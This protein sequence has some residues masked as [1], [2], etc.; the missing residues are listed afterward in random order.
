MLWDYSEHGCAKPQRSRSAALP[1]P[2]HKLPQRQCGSCCDSHCLQHREDD[3]CRASRLP[4]HTDT[5]LRLESRPWH[6]HALHEVS[7]G[8]KCIFQ[9]M[10]TFHLWTQK[11]MYYTLANTWNL[12]SFFSFFSGLGRMWPD[13]NN[14]RVL[15]VWHH[16]V[17]LSFNKWSSYLS[18]MASLYAKACWILWRLAVNLTLA[19]GTI[20]ACAVVALNR[21][22]IN[23]SDW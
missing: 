12:C 18:L 7:H 22:N 3:V 23:M 11:L 5:Q 10:Y 17:G 1:A 13:G 4:S 19:C 20:K 21:Q 6:P 9:L 16:M 15:C 8:F 14:V 2:N